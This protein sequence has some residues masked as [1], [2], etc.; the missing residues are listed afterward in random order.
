[1]A[2]VDVQLIQRLRAGNV[3][4]GVAQDPGDTIS[5]TPE[6]ALELYSHGYALA[7][8]DTTVSDL[9]AAVSTLQAL[10]AAKQDS[11]GAATDA[12]L[13]AAIAGV[14]SALAAKQDSG[15]AATDTELSDAVAALNATVSSGLALKQDASSAATD[16][17]LTAAIN[18]LSSSVTTSLG[19]KQD[20]ST[21]ATDAELAAHASDSSLHSSGQR[22]GYA[23]NE[24]GTVQTITVTSTAIPS[25]A[26]AL[27]QLSR[28]QVLHARCHVKFSVAMTATAGTVTDLVL[29]I[30]DDLGAFVDAG[31]LSFDAATTSAYGTIIATA[32][33]P[34]DAAART[35]HLEISRGGST[36]GTVQVLN[37]AIST[38]NRS[39]L[40]AVAA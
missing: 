4:T 33:I 37:G 15:T 7:P 18:A 40:R 35:Y 12:E 20:A 1:M 6:Q 24:T 38:A 26:V 9:S 27:P 25:T 16:A 30:V 19:L 28:P 32:D 13:A 8:A 2:N 21:A 39:A 11:T 22:T 36:S 3:Y 17:E 14:T 29:V 5:V 23:A 31:Y 10:V 34:A